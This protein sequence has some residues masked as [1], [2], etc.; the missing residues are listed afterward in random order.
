MHNCNETLNVKGSTHSIVTISNAMFWVNKV[1]FQSTIFP[2][3][4]ISLY[5][6]PS[7]IILAL[8]LIN[9]L[10]L[11]IP[12]KINSSTGTAPHQFFSSSHC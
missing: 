5:Y 7:K 8:L 12:V 11:T 4:L 1:K 6:I 2:T 9:V 10:L 3:F